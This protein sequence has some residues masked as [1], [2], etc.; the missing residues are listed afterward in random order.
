MI[1]YFHTRAHIS[2]FFSFS[3]FWIRLSIY[4][5]VIACMQFVKTVQ[6]LRVNHRYWLE[7]QEGSANRSVTL[8]LISQ[9]LHSYLV[10]YNEESG[11]AIYVRGVNSNQE[12]C[13]F[14]G[15]ER[16]NGVSNDHTPSIISLLCKMPPH[17]SL[18]IG[19]FI[20][21]LSDSHGWLFSWHNYI[22]TSMS[23]INLKL[24]R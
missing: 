24:L 11:T 13:W 16:K 14:G 8:R 22:T 3:F 10:I 5:P 21:A 20:H 6:F 2:C 12:F 17:H 18:F 7:R 15:G 19:S 9:K 4:I 1:V 23:A